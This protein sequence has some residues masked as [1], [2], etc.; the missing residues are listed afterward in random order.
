MFSK[1][2]LYF[3]PLYNTVGNYVIICSWVKLAP[4][5]SLQAASVREPLVF[6]VRF[7]AEC[8]FPH[9]WDRAPIPLTDIKEPV[10]IH[11]EAL[12]SS[13]H[14][15]THMHD[16]YK[17]KKQFPKKKKSN[18]TSVVKAWEMGRQDPFQRTQHHMVTIYSILGSLTFSC[19]LS[20]QQA[21]IWYTDRHTG[22]SYT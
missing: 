1:H 22:D 2:T 17:T 12:Y 19:G 3:G 4:C 11:H 21:H 5:V 9:C 13:L 10:S 8:H 14:P 15:H 6:I 16:T 18:K 7:F 20:G